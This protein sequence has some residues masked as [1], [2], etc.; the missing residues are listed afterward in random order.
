MARV[1][2]TKE[3]HQKQQRKGRRE[4]A[5]ARKAARK[6]A[7]PPVVRRK[8]PSRQKP[9]APPKEAAPPKRIR[10]KQVAM[11]VTQP[12]IRRAPQRTARM[13]CRGWLAYRKEAAARPAAPPAAAPPVEIKQ[14]EVVE[15]GQPNGEPAVEPSR[16]QEADE[17]QQNGAMNF[18]SPP[19]TA[20][21]EDV[22]TFKVSL[23][24]AGC[25][26]TNV[27]VARWGRLLIVSVAK[28]SSTAQFIHEKYERFECRIPAAVERR[29][30]KAKWAEG[31]RLV[32]A[33][34][35]DELLAEADGQE[36]EI[37]IEV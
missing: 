6:E 36:Q 7:T 5:G 23:E 2:Q 26:P 15:D 4:E 3:A 37:P 17:G 18:V 11:K 21:V 25:L 19:A 30:F 12:T 28:R 35:Q 20:T 16:N 8:Q 1:M 31:E 24:L 9:P 32:I 14:E 29:V 22:Q 27:H 10:R 13:T 34:Q 33:A